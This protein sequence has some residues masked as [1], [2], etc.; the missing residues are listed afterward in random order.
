MIINL[1]FELQYP[2][3]NSY[4]CFFL[5]S[6]YSCGSYFMLPIKR[7]PRLTNNNNNNNNNKLLIIFI[8]CEFLRPV[9][10]GM[11]SLKFEWSGWSRF[12]L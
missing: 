11:N 8:N 12:S 3:I 4:R 10:T 5:F 9:L 6:V 2:F 1:I 7:K